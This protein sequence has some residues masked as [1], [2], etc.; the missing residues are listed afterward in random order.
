M[1]LLWMLYA[2]ATRLP[3]KSMVWSSS[4]I[5]IGEKESRQVPLVVVS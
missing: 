3:P 5:R 2:T 4:L 1:V